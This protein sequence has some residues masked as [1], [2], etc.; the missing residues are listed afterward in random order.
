MKDRGP[1][2]RATVRLPHVEMEQHR[3]RVTVREEDLHCHGILS[4]KVRSRCV[5]NQG[6]RAFR[7]VADIRRVSRRVVRE[8]HAVR[9]R[10]RAVFGRR[11]NFRVDPAEGGQSAA[12]DCGLASKRVAP[13][14]VVLLTV[15]ILALA[16]RAVGAM[17]GGRFYTAAT[18][19]RPAQL[20]RSGWIGCW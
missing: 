16:S 9:D 13:L 1:G 15:I 18:A 6:R 20:E 4:G 17:A 12:S 5:G 8:R 7:R 11:D 19:P 3:G 10:D 2:A 14:L